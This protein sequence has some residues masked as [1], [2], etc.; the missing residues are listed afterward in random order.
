MTTATNASMPKSASSNRARMEFMASPSQGSRALG[1]GGSV[2]SSSCRNEV[3]HAAHV[4]DEVGP[5]LAAQLVDVDRHRIALDFFAPAVQ[6]VF[7]L[8]ARQQGAGMR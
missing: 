3:A 6:P 8:R 7:E 1:P 2:C 5:E 4:L